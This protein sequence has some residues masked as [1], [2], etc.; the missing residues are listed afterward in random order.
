[1]PTTQSSWVMVQSTPTGQDDCDGNNNVCQT[2]H[3]WC[4]D[5]YRFGQYIMIIAENCAINRVAD[6][7][8]STH[9]GLL[10]MT[11]CTYIQLQQQLVGLIYKRIW[12]R[13]TITWYKGFIWWMELNKFSGV[14]VVNLVAFFNPNLQHQIPWGRCARWHRIWQNQHSHGRFQLTSWLSMENILVQ[15]YQWTR[16]R[17]I[18][19]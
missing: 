16:G 2:P 14:G 10:T 18:K 11:S 15:F 6:V 17:E 7:M 8:I 4:V 13:N 3:R 12:I 19:F 9:N 5:Y 1:M